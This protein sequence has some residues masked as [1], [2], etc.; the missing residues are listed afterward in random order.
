MDI[1]MDVWY[2]IEFYSTWGIDN[3]S[4]TYVDGYLRFMVVKPQ[5]SFNMLGRHLKYPP[6]PI[7]LWILQYKRKPE[8]LNTSISSIFDEETQN[9]FIIFFLMSITI[10][11][12]HYPKSGENPQHS[13]KTSKTTENPKHTPGFLLYLSRT[14]THPS[15]NLTK[16]VHRIVPGSKSHHRLTKLSRRDYTESWF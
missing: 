9:C 16:R 3:E 15:V 8:K 4:G 2:L 13:F 11:I 6:I 1:Y 7:I 14:P 10:S 12:L 5:L